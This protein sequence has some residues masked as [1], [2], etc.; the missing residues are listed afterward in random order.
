MMIQRSWGGWY[1]GWV[2]FWQ[3]YFFY[4]NVKV[5]GRVMGWKAG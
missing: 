4:Q 5:L 1:S 3:R 2:L